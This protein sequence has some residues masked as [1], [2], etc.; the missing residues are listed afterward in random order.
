M[1][2][3]VID[4]VMGSGK[5]S[6][7]HEYMRKNKDK[8]FIY[9]TPYLGEVER[10]IK[11]CSNFFIPQAIDDQGQKCLKKDSFYQLLCEGKNIAST[12]QLF[13]KMS[14][15]ILSILKKQAYELV[16]DE[17]MGLIDVE[18]HGI[19]DIKM[20]KNEDRI[21]CDE[22][23]RLIWN[24]DKDYKGKWAKN[25]RTLCKS[26]TIY[27]VNDRFLVWMLPSLIFNYFEN[28]YILT[29]MFDAQIM[30]F[31]FDLNSL[32]Y[33]KYKIV[34]K[35]PNF[36]M[37]PYNESES[38]YDGM[39]FSKLINICTTGK[40]N[41][42]GSLGRTS[43][44]I[45]RYNDVLLSKTW[46]GKKQNFKQLDQMKKNLENF[47]RHNGEGVESALWTTFK[48]FMKQLASRRYRDF[49]AHNARAT[50]N[51][52]NKTAVAYTVNKFMNQPIKAFLVAKGIH[53]TQ[54][55]EEKYALSELL[56]FIFRTAIRDGK[57]INLYLPSIRMRYLLQNWLGIPNE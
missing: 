23:G 1:S 36:K 55:V 44:G 17:A 40:I 12:H 50:N 34:G 26:K 4:S 56:Q 43:I 57:C 20:L 39:P 5:S 21:Y 45:D 22:M 19:D 6:Y 25:I 38:L 52:R 7:I 37:V 29:Y 53:I 51:Y 15:D 28:V 35:H 41:K 30:K 31:Y 18:E 3:K 10:T 54:E 13:R 2:I 33:N 27:I 48:D 24:E 11:D 46:Y 9:I 49:L 16:I 42:I 47:F 32:N 14:F 8:K